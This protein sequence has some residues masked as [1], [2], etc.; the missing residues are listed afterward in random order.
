MYLLIW[1]ILL[2]V[3]LWA[4]ERFYLRGKRIGKY[5]VPNDPD[6]VIS[7]TRPDGPGPEHMEVV[8]T[9]RQLTT[10][11]SINMRGQNLQA[12]R[13]S[14]DGLSDN[15]DYVSDFIPANAGGV[16]AEWVLAPGADPTRRVLYIHGGGFIMG[17]PKSHRTITSKF[18]EVS[19]CAVLSIDY[20]LMP[21]N[22]HMDAVIDCR[23]AYRWILVNGPDG[24][25]PIRQLFI[26]GDSAGANLG[27]SLVA[28]L[29]DNGLRAPEAVVALSP[30]SD[31]TFSGSSIRDNEATDV[32]LRPV[33]RR[34]N[35]I[36]PFIKSWWVLWTNRM[37]PASPVASPLLGDLSRLPPTLV[38][39]SEAEMLLDDARRYVY[40]ACAAG[41]PAKLQTW[42]D[43][44]HVW[45]LFE[46]ELPQ[47]VEAWQEIEKFLK[48]KP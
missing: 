7:F 27:L 12:A 3:F 31:M 23:E 8:R 32:M 40:K 10:Q 1:P 6:S 46:P 35:R 11:I 22:R 16:P 47:A 39:A 42:A 38:Q 45:Q 30:L 43:V 41:S 9:I 37:R 34:L 36:P 4:F 5:P 44:V 21:E 26:S 29:R 48:S 17:S 19:G 28:W 13:T 15:R 24:P 20:R 2:V 18:S 25:G 33:L 14:I